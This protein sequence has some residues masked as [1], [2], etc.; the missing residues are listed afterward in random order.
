M[1]RISPY[2]F[3]HP[4]GKYYFRRV[5]PKHLQNRLQKKEIK[6]AL[7]SDKSISILKAMKLVIKTDRM[8]AR[9]E[10][11]NYKEVNQMLKLPN[12]VECALKTFI[13]AKEAGIDLTALP[14]TTPVTTDNTIQA[15]ENC[16]TLSQLFSKFIDHKKTLKAC[17]LFITAFDSG[18]TKRI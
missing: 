10:H 4:N 14:S 18:R 8:F 3:L 7:E 6:K 2:L 15:P 5:V 9:G 16:L 13:Q 1:R 17:R 11:N 12:G